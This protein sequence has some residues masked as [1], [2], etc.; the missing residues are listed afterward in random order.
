MKEHA[1]QHGARQPAAARWPEPES[2]GELLRHLAANAGSGPADDQPTGREGVLGIA[3]GLSPGSWHQQNEQT[4]RNS[5]RWSAV[6]ARRHGRTRLVGLSEL[7]AN[8]SYTVGNR[9]PRS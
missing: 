1:R 7:T 2:S 9:L 4:A 8:D 3:T 5:S 6:S